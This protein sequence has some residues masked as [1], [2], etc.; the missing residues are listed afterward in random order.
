MNHPGT[1]VAPLPLPAVLVIGGA[2]MDIVAH[3]DTLLLRSDSNPG[4]VH[5]AAGGVARNVA[6]NLALLGQRTALV[7]VLGQDAFGQTVL[8]ATQAAGVDTRH[9]AQ[10]SDAGTASYLSLHGPDG[11][12]AVAVND[13]SILERL[14]ADFLAPLAAEL[15]SASCLV[16]DCN[17]HEEALGFLLRDGFTVPVFVDAVSAAKCQRLLPWLASVHTL[18]VNRLEAATLTGLTVTALEEAQV[19]AKTLHRLGVRQVVLSLG[20]QGVAWCDA[21][22]ATGFRAARRVPV[23]NTNGAGDALLAGL[24]HGYLQGWDLP[25]AV[26]WAMTCAEITLQ[27]P[28]ANALDLSTA[29]VQARLTEAH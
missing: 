1:N 12:M 8:Q 27:S 14:D 3:T 21:Q 29:T 9:C 16:L 18:K 7:S 10:L 15:A 5:C 23:L 17:L 6:H 13:M 4:H 2:N 22:G 25:R 11:D 20:Q 26:A 28:T 24:V 19:A